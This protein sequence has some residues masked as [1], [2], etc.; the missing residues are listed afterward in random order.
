M[1]KDKANSF[2]VTW[3]N[4]QDEGG[5]TMID[6]E[7]VD[8]SGVIPSRWIHACFRNGG[9]PT[10]VDEAFLQAAA[11]RMITLMIDEWNA[12]Q[13]RLAATEGVVE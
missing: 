1:P 12:E 5:L 8:D 13:E 9:D 7:L 10:V 2:T 4:R 11:E 3:K 6:V